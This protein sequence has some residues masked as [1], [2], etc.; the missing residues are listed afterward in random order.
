MCLV[1]QIYNFFLTPNRGLKLPT[2][3]TTC[4]WRK[5]ENGI[6]DV[7][8]NCDAGRRSQIVPLRSVN[9]NATAKVLIPSYFYPF[10]FKQVKLSLYTCTTKVKL[11]WTGPQGFGKLRIPEFLDN[12]H[13]KMAR[14]STQRTGRLYPAGDIPGILL[15]YRLSPPQGHI[16][17]GRIKSTLIFVP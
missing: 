10:V 9:N 2:P 14:L 7:L 13:M 15:C 1:Y 11:S 3:V 4:T 12:R 17:A 5:T 8:P 6:S 16:P